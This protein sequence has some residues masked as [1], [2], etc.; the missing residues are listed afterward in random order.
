ML[1]RGWLE[2]LSFIALFRKDSTPGTAVAIIAIRP[3][4]QLGA[5][6]FIVLIFTDVTAGT[7]V[8]INSIHTNIPTIF[9]L[10]FLLPPCPI[11]FIES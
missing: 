5:V 7:A 8:A 2:T 10:M 1:A 6:A 9:V 4:G 3:R 11:L